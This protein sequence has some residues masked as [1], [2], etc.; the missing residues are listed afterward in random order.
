VRF[1][2]LTAVLTEVQV[3]WDKMS[4]KLAKISL[5]QGNF[6]LQLQGPI[7]NF[8]DPEDEG[9]K[10]VRNVGDYLRINKSSYARRLGSSVSVFKGFEV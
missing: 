5:H 3:I 10:L 1:K 4:S 6:C 7:Q 2:V 8:L 9:R